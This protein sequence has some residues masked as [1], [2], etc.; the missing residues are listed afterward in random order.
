MKKRTYNIFI[1]CMIIICILCGIRT[2]QTARAESIIL[3]GESINV[4]PP[5]DQGVFDNP[6]YPWTITTDDGISSIYITPPMADGL[7]PI[8]NVYG[9]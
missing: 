7:A 5:L 1:I 4:Q 3:N 8:I 9:P 2:I 6:S